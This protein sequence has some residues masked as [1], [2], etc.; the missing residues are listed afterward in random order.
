MHIGLLSFPR[1]AQHSVCSLCRRLWNP[2]FRFPFL[3]LPVLTVLRK[4]EHIG[5]S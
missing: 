1:G 2:A 4:S 3:K 5:R